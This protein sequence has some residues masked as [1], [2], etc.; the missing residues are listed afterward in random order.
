MRHF[1]VSVTST[2]TIKKSW[3]PSFQV[4][5]TSSFK[6][7]SNNLTLAAALAQARN[8]KLV[9]PEI[10]GWTQLPIEDSTGQVPT[11]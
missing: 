6:V 8:L 5:E 2:V 9:D 1:L 10:I 11:V 7:R 3:L 4:R